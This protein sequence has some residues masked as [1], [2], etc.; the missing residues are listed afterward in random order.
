MHI[1]TR[2]EGKGGE[3]GKVGK[4]SRR[5]DDKQSEGEDH[6][7]RCLV[8]KGDTPRRSRW[9]YQRLFEFHEFGRWNGN[10]GEQR[11]YERVRGGKR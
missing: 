11:R 3:E 10:Q 2:E 5:G 9:Q 4:R 7:G 1:K 8:G 6:T